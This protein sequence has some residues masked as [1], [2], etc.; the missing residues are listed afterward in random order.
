[1]IKVILQVFFY[2]TFSFLTTYISLIKMFDIMWYINQILET[3]RK[4]DRLSKILGQLIC[5]SPNKFNIELIILL[6]LYQG[7]G[8][9]CKSREGVKLGQSLQASR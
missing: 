8:R 1:M 4:C 2:V 3:S 7:R 9:W 6:V 5:L